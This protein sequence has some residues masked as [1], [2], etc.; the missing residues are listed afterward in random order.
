MAFF[1][2]TDF[3]G[4]RCELNI[5]QYSRVIELP[6]EMRVGHKNRTVTFG[7]PDVST[8]MR[9]V[10]STHLIFVHFA[11]TLFRPVKRTPKSA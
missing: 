8:N 11:A 2:Q 4:S 5:K 10:D 3:R 6:S 7:V 9:Y 1:A